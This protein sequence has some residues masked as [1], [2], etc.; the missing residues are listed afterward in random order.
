M[1]VK[2]RYIKF[3]AHVSLICFFYCFILLSPIAA[4][5]K[6]K[7]RADKNAETNNNYQQ[8]QEFLKN[9]DFE[10][11]IEAFKITVQ[12]SP[13]HAD[14]YNF[15]GEAYYEREQM[16]SAV[17][18][19]EKA[20]SIN[21]KHVRAKVNLEVARWAL[22]M[23][24]ERGKRIEGWPEMTLQAFSGYFNGAVIGTLAYLGTSL[25]G[26]RNDEMT[27]PI[28]TGVGLIL[29]GS[30][31][32]H[33]IGEF[34]GYGGGSHANTTAGALIPPFIGALLATRNRH[35]EG[36][37]VVYGATYGSLLSPIAA[38]I[39]YQLSKRNVLGL[40]RIPSKKGPPRWSMSTQYSK[41]WAHVV[42]SVHFFF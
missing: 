15:M 38:T 18:S 12:L 10:R 32:V 16:Q 19:F 20:I 30:S 6:N 4:A 28:C 26:I 39:G 23:E 37:E 5:P 13:N 17:E 33:W 11:A 9:R 3:H 14:A 35:N 21:P 22:P 36:R 25:A 2:V 24:E 41:T 8:G 40:P 42:T 31:Q 29:G 34:W 7:N 1:V 27:I